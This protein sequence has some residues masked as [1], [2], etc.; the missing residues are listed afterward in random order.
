[1]K[2]LSIGNSF[3]QDAHK[4]LH[5]LAV[6]CG[7][8]LETVNLYIG[9]CSLETHWKNVEEENE[10]YELGR[11]G[12][13]TERMITIQEALTMDNWD[14]ITVQQVS[15]FS[16]MPESYEPYLSNLVALIRKTCP[17]AKLYFHQTWAYEID[18]QH[19]AFVNYG[20]D[21]HTMFNRILATSQQMAEKIGAQLIPAGA[22]IQYL[23]EN[24]TDFDYANGGLSLCRDGFHMSWDYGRFAVAAIWLR[25]LVG[26]PIATSTFEDFDSDKVAKI[27]QCANEMC[28]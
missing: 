17:N 1:M 7:I 3:S 24:V 9:G 2:L 8:D 6:A 23:R 13:N 20:N 11:N 28:N 18:S 19:P 10:Y 4:W 22:F 21:Q 5:Q 25:T 12:G 27:L 26:H 15:N 16:G 14:V